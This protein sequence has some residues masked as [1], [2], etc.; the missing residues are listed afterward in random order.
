MMINNEFSVQRYANG[1][2]VTTDDKYIKFIS[3]ISL[4]PGL[5]PILAQVFSAV[6]HKHFYVS[7]SLK[8]NPD[9]LS[10]TPELCNHKLIMA[11][12]NQ[13]VFFA[14]YKINDHI[15]PFNTSGF[16][17]CKEFLLKQFEMKNL[18][19]IKIYE[20]EF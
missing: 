19:I 12:K 6:D 17:T 9:I 16:Y 3:I 2:K 7:Y 1:E 5:Y 11:P 15:F 14:L 10:M 20:E 13:K 4:E 18:E 8:G